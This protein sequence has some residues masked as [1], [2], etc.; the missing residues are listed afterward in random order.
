MKK[1]GF[2][3]G[4]NMAEALAHGLIVHKIFKPAELIVSDVDAGGRRK[5]LKRKLKIAVTGDNLE[6]I[7]QSRAILFAVK[8]QTIDDVLNRWRSGEL[9]P[10]PKHHLFI[11]I[12]GRSP[13]R[14]LYVHTSA[15]ERG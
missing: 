13:D 15:H 8:P 1:L 12:A 7:A 9:G 11:S 10:N 5:N 3:G 4:G 2:I 14:A 6:V